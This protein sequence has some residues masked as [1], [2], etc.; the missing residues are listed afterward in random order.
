MNIRRLAL[1]AAL[2]AAAPVAFAQ[3]QTTTANMPVTINVTNTCTVGAGTLNFGDSSLAAAAGGQ[4]NVNVTCS[5]K[6]AYSLAF[7][8]G[9]NAVTGQRRMRHATLTDTLNYNLSGASVGGAALTGFSSTS[10]G[11]NVAN[12][13]TVYGQV[14]SGQSNK[15]TGTYN[16]SVLV[17]LTY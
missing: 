11:G 5:N 2:F 8:D 12:V 16:D 9:V 6:G 10:T 17:T 7:N 13:H 3:S 4:T 15:A 1:A 14:P